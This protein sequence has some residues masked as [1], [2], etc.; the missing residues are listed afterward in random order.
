MSSREPQ[1]APHFSF[2]LIFSEH[3]CIT[4][5]AHVNVTDVLELRVEKPV[6]MEMG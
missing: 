4:V 1:H 3:M 5:V 2:D 6:P